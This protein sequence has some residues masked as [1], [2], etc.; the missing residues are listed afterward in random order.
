MT[1]I[2]FS[3]G[4]LTW[5]ILG[6]LTPHRIKASGFHC[7]SNERWVSTLSCSTKQILVM[8]LTYKYR[9]SCSVGAAISLN[10]RRLSSNFLW[11]SRKAFCLC[12]P[13]FLHSIYGKDNSVVGVSC[14]VVLPEV[15]LYVSNLA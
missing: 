9:K 7:T 10:V 3:P 12:D 6:L 14:I 4:V 11:G 8:P 13:S 5:L 2:S 15:L 1:L